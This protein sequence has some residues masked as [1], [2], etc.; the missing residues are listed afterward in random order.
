M[1]SLTERIR[2]IEKEEI[3]KALRESEWVMSRAAK[4]L[5]ITERMV[6]YKI[7]KYRIKREVKFGRVKT[8][9]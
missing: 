6:G 9:I 3:L 2:A 4:S 1:E 8:V 5:G 7:K